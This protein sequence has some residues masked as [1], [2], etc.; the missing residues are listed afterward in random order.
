[1]PTDPAWR[2]TLE[3]K[4]RQSTLQLL[5]KAARLVNE[6]ALARV[7]AQAPAPS[8]ASGPAVELRPA[9]AALFPHIDLD[10]T[11]LSTLAARAGISKQAV[12][13]LVD[14][15]EGQGMVERIPDPDDGRA[16]LVRFTPLGQQALLHGLSVLQQ[17]QAEL[18]DR[19][20]A[21]HMDALH[22]ALLALL[23]EVEP[24]T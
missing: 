23:R 19:I 22:E 4:K 18:A 16:R 20:G 1:M 24:R 13:Q 17:L 7:R 11:R 3:E 8:S 6:Q 14:D 15:L 2:R 21:S 12:G 9:H 5:F 10:G